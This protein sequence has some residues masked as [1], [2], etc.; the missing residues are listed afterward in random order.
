MGSYS[1][2]TIYSGKKNVIFQRH[3]FRYYGFR[4]YDN[5]K[6]YIL[7]IRKIYGDSI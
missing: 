5:N 7:N 4:I 1:I 3:G 6:I 2:E